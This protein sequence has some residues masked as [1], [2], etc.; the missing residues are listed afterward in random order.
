MSAPTP[1]PGPWVCE[2]STADDFLRQV[3]AGLD[4]YNQQESALASVQ[5][6]AVAA[7]S[8]A[9][10]VVGGV[11]GRTW[12]AC[13]EIQ[14]L[15]VA[16]AQRRQGAGTALLHSFH[17]EAAQRGCTLVYLETFSFQAPDFYLAL[18]YTCCQVIEGFPGGI[19]K[20]LMQIHLAPTGHPPAAV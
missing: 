17:S 13:A 4:A 3:D 10:S 11:V 5:P 9:G 1:A 14:Q 12:G 19:K 7:T 18:G 6:L 15:W 8:S 2:I 16:P 20:Y